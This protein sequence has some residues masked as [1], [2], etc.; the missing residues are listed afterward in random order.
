[1]TGPTQ[2]RFLKA[3]PGKYWD[4]YTIGNDVFEKL[5]SA[6]VEAGRMTSWAFAGRYLPRGRASAYDFISFKKFPNDSAMD[7]MDTLE[8]VVEEARDSLTDDEQE[9]IRSVESLRTIVKQEI[10]RQAL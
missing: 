10:W 6:H 5:H 9:A 3:A 4:Y 7:A 8:Y 2:A 1:M